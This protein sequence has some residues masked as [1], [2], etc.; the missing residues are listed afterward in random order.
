MVDDPDLRGWHVLRYRVRDAD[1]VQAFLDLG[2]V[3][4]YSERPRVPTGDDEA[5]VVFVPPDAMAAIDAADF[6]VI[7]ERAVKLRVRR[8]G[9]TWRIEGFIVGNVWIE[10]RESLTAVADL[11]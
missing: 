4:L 3:K 6:P 7:P 1:V 10:T 2:D 11:T 8:S 5:L 9:D